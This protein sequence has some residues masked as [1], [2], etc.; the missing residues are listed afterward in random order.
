MKMHDESHLILPPQAAVEWL[1]LI[2]HRQKSF[3]M[4]LSGDPASME[5]KD[6]R[7]RASFFE[8]RGKSKFCYEQVFTTAKW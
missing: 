2:T 3:D 6:A 1:I 8:G 4:R 7:L 5:T